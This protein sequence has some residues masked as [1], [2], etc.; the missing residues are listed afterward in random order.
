MLSR[1]RDVRLLD[2]LHSIFEK[3]MGD[4]QSDL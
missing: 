3:R 1:Q 4:L 2:K